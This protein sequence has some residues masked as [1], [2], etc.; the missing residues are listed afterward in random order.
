MESNFN[1]SILE[2]LII[3][4]LTKGIVV[5]GIGTIITAI[6]IISDSMILPYMLGISFLGISWLFYKIIPAVSNLNI[7]KHLNIFGILKTE[8]LYGSYLNF[9][10]LNIQF[11]E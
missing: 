8:N 7:I 11:Q 1:G 3:S 4:I 6:C 9:N 5:F 2:Y 10:F